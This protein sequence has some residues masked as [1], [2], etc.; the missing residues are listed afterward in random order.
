MDNQD[1]DDNDQ[2]AAIN[3]KIDYLKWQMYGFIL[4][5]LLVSC[6]FYGITILENPGLKPTRN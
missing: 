5:S 6:A 2:M 4:L 3:A 1:G